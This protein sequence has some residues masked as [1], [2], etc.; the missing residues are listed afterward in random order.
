MRDLPR[1]VAIPLSHY[2]ERARW[3][4][5]EAGVDYWEDQHLQVF[6]GKLTR[7][8]GATH[9][10]PVL[11]A[12]GEIIGD[13]S[14]IVRW[15]ARHSAQRLFP[16]DTDRVEV[17][18]LSEELAG[19]YGVETRRLAY[20]WFFRN[21]D[22]CISYNEGAAPRH[23]AWLLRLGKRRVVPQM[24]R[25]LGL[26][27]EKL[28]AGREIVLR[29]M[30]GIAQRLADGRPY[31]FGDAFS[32]ADLTFAA[33][34]APSIVPERHPVPYPP[35]ERLDEAAVAHI[36]EMRA[37]P[38]GAF[39]LRMYA[40]RPAVRARLARRLVHAPATDVAAP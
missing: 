1:L 13:S 27:E 6:A 15:A 20:G 7:R 38:A 33:L 40:R 35:L 24:Q 34:S 2:C 25:Y 28:R 16:S 3:A 22:A 30:D 10:V 11:A 37:H 9:T 19:S 8:L 12:A 18:A 26:R 31:L 32:A 14:G 29:T 36:E 23:Q 21:L 4:L 17:E 39:A 5:D